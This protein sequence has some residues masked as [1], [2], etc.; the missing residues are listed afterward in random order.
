MKDINAN[1]EISMWH[2]VFK[3]TDDAARQKKKKKMHKFHSQQV[4]GGS[5]DPEVKQHKCSD[6]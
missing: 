6:S 3:N 1:E 2:V 4:L 5:L